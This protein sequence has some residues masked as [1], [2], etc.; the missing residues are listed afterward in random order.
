[1]KTCIGD[2]V[3]PPLGKAALNR[4]IDKAEEITV[5][6]FLSHCGVTPDIREDMAEYPDDYEFCRSVNGIYYYVWSAVEHFYQ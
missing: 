2:C 5:H 1:M 4:I 3:N 6:E